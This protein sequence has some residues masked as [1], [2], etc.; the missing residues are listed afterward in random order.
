[1]SSTGAW[2]A[3]MSCWNLRGYSSKQKRIAQLNPDRYPA[4]GTL[5]RGYSLIKRIP[6]SAEHTRPMVYC[7]RVPEPGTKAG[8]ASSDERQWGHD[9]NV[10]IDMVRAECRNNP[11]DLMGTTSAVLNR[12]SKAQQ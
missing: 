9:I 6:P 11:A 3:V 10:L 1:M 12:F 8:R 5:F 4:R 2:C 7:R